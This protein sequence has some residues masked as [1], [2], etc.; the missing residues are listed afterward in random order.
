VVGFDDIQ[1]AEFQHP[2]LTTIRQPLRKMG[3]TAAEVVLRGVRKPLDERNVAEIVVEPEL[4][5]RES[6][7]D[8]NPGYVASATAGIEARPL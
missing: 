1:S 2:G 4:I 5:V 8:V 3:K 7:C 6:S